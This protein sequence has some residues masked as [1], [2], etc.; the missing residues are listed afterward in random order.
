MSNVLLSSSNRRGLHFHC[1]LGRKLGT[2]SCVLDFLVLLK[3]FLQ[4]DANRLICLAPN[5]R[6][7]LIGSIKRKYADSEQR[8]GE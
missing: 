3:D 8:N 4:R 2:S 5:R 7:G 1:L 6:R